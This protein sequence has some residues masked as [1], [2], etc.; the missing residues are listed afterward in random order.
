MSVAPGRVRALLL[1]S[2]FALVAFALLMSLGVWQLHRLA[3]KEGL[4][5]QIGERLKAPALLLP[6]ASAWGS[7]SQAADEY[8]HVTA[9]G[10]FEHDKEAFVFRTAGSG[11][12]EAG[13]YVLTP[14]RLDGG[15]TILVNRGFVPERLRD[16]S[17]RTADQAAGD[18]TVSGVLRWPEDRN[19]FTP[20]DNPAT[21]TWYTRDPPAIAKALGLADAAP[22][23]LDADPDPKGTALRGGA[24]TVNI[25]NDHLSYALTWFGLA[26]TLLVVFGLVVWRRLQA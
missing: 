15:G 18:V 11:L 21:R 25:R 14:L 12:G 22:F 17:Q 9:K 26:A 5:A 3:W 20:A 13:F 19:M 8:R 4:L 7:L 1:P 10:V 24:T 23:S 2:L 6:P 16:P